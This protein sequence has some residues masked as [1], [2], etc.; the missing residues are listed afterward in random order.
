MA[1]AAA[2]IIGGSILMDIEVNE[3]QGKDEEY[4]NG[5]TN[6]YGDPGI[7]REAMG[8]CTGGTEVGEIGR[9]LVGEDVRRLYGKW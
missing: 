9:R 5:N 1:V 2:G 8:R 4:G 3:E 6:R 7:V